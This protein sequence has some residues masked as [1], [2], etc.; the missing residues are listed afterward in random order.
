MISIQK[1]SL[2]MKLILIAKNTFVWLSQLSEKYKF[3]I[4]RLDQIPD[5]ELD[6]MSRWGIT[7]LWLIGIWERSAASKTI[8]RWCGNPEAESSMPSR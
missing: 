7:G 2:M 8:K 1:M 3:P 4:E 5:E 6:M